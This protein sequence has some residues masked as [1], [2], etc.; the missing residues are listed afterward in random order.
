MAKYFQFYTVKFEVDKIDPNNMLKTKILCNPKEKSTSNWIDE[1]YNE[2]KCHCDVAFLKEFIDFYLK[3]IRP[4]PEFNGVC[5][6]QVIADRNHDIFDEA[7]FDRRKELPEEEFLMARAE[8]E[9]PKLSDSPSWSPE[10]EEEKLSETA[11]NFTG[12]TNFQQRSS[13]FSPVALKSETNSVSSD[14]IKT[15]E[16]ILNEGWEIDFDRI[17]PKNDKKIK[18]IYTPQNQDQLN[19]VSQKSSPIDQITKSMTIKPIE[20]KPWVDH[21]KKLCCKDS[22]DQWLKYHEDEAAPVMCVKYL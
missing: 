18:V 7:I 2:E 8:V 10:E 3:E 1:D 14:Q 11:Q 5:Q 16:E 13:V 6:N 12:I 22:S 9:S 21:S 4:N 19:D 20:I 17:T 15:D